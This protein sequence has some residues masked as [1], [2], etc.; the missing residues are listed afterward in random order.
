MN[1]LSLI[2]KDLPM[3]IICIAVAIFIAVMWGYSFEV[4]IVAPIVGVLF[5]ILLVWDLRLVLPLLLVLLP[6]GP[7]FQMAFGNLYLATAVM[8]AVYVAWIVRMPVVKRRPSFRYSVISIGLVA[9]MLVLVVSGLQHL[10]FLLANRTN[11]LRLIQFFLYSGLFIIVYDID[12]SL[13]EMRRLLI[14]ALVAGVAQGMYGAYQ[15]L[16]YPGFY[17]SGSFDGIHNHFGAYVAFIIVLLLGLVFRARRWATVIVSLV[18]IA[19]LLYALVFSFSRTAYVALAVS[20]FVFF[21]MPIGKRNKAALG[22]VSASGVLIGLAVIPM[23]VGQ[24]MLDI[25]LT[26]TG[27]QMALSFYYRM[28]MW[29]GALADFARSPFLGRGTYFYDLRD[30]FYLKVIGENGLLGLVTLIVLL[31]LV[32]REEKR[33]LRLCTGDDVIDGLTLGLFP[34]T[35]GFLVVF[36][37]AGDF[38]LIH[39]L[40]GTFWITLALILRYHVVRNES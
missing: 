29:R 32:L 27:K 17:V 13:K 22:A 19:L 10:N 5:F 8:M 16:R 9:F 31:Y 12:L 35:V 1:S 21:F 30:N 36:N 2:E 40:M 20:I 33:L 23:A 26:F 25:Y 37:L 6:F 4:N 28:G 24:R 34:A 15:W 38:F 11:L 3:V 39:K 14:L 18:S 7:K